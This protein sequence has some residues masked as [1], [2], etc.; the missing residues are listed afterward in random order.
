VKIIAIKA[1]DTLSLRNTI[2]RPDFSLEQ[3]NYPG[4]SDV[5]THHLGCIINKELVGIVSIYK[6]TNSTA[7]SGCGFQIRAMATCETVRNKGIGIKL[8]VKNFK[9]KV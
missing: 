8:M 4:D 5:S 6:I 2:L 3:C 9:L 7:H 1:S